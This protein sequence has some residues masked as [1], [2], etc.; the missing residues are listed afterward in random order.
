M[1]KL[2]KQTNIRSLDPKKRKE[3][4][5]MIDNIIENRNKQIEIFDRNIIKQL[6]RCIEVAKETKKGNYPIEYMQLVNQ[7]CTDYL[8]KFLSGYPG[9]ETTKKR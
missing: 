3:L 6:K 2:E 9:I 5:K 8:H 7:K 1:I 4:A